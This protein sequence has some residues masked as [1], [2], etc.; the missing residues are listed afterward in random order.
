MPTVLTLQHLAFEDLGY[1]NE[2]LIRYGYHVH[3]LEVPVISLENIE[4]LATDVWIVLGGPIGVYETDSYPFLGQEL[5]LIAKRS[6]AHL[7]CHLVKNS[8][9]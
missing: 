8:P 6:S 7:H 9:L 2:I 1:F 4:P 3:T 5:D